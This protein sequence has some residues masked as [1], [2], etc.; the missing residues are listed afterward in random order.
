MPTDGSENPVSSLCLQIAQLVPLYAA[1]DWQRLRD[2]LNKRS[3]PRESTIAAP[4]PTKEALALA[5]PRII[6]AEEGL[7][8]L[9]AVDR[10]LESAWFLNP[11]AYEV[12]TGFEVCFQ[13]QLVPL[14]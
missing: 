11:R 3:K 10:Q 7:Y 4:P 5:E 1:D 9:N 2:A 12:K 8:K 6:S 13:I 14:H